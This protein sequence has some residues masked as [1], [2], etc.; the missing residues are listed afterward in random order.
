MIRVKFVLFSNYFRQ[1]IAGG[2]TGG[3]TL[4]YGEQLNHTNA[5][6]IYLDFSVTS[7]RIAQRRARMRSLRN[8]IWIRSWIEDARFLGIG[9][10]NELQCS[11]V[12]H[13]LKSPLFGLNILKNILKPEGSMALMVYAKYGRTAIYQIQHLMKMTNSYSK[14]MIEMELKNTKHVLEVLPKHNWFIINSLVND[15]KTGNSGIYDLFLHKRD[16][17]YSFETLFHWIRNGG[18]HFVDLDDYSQRYLIKPQYVFL[19]YNTRKS[20]SRF[21]VSK[22]FHA[23]EILHGNVFKHSF[24]VSKSQNTIADVHDESNVIFTV[25]VSRELRQAVNNKNNYRKY[26]NQTFF[27]ARFNRHFIVKYQTDLSNQIFGNNLQRN[28]LATS[29]GIIVEYRSNNFTTFIMKRLCDSPGGVSLKCLHLEYQR[30]LNSSN[31]KNEYSLLLEE[32]FNSVKDSEVF[33][34]KKDYVSPFPKTFNNFLTIDSD[35][36]IGG[37]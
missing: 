4:F 12:L 9:L 27:R 35:A 24:F 5:E 31:S 25:G 29:Y 8:I 16:V 21:D 2:G 17:A 7:M 18:L 1:I 22:Q 37:V 34:L 11:G 33:L 20:I 19:D 3:V 28:H 36:T 14:N 6:I 32:F 13:H 26:E 15:H 23:A 30:K 10:F